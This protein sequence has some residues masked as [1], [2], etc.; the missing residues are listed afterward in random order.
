MDDELFEVLY[1]ISCQLW[2]SREKRVQFSGRTIVLLY[3]WSVIRNKPRS[4]VCHR[5]NLPA[6]LRDKPIPSQSQF[7]RRLNSTAVAALL[8]QME[9]SVRRTR[10]SAMLGCWILDGKPLPVSPYTKDKDAQLGWSYSGRAHGYKLFLMVDAEGQLAAWR[11]GG[12]NGGEPTIARSLLERTDRPGYVLGD[13]VYDS[14]PLHE[15]AAE[16]G[17]QLIAPRKQPRANIGSQSRHPSRLHA[18]DMLETFNNTFGPSMYAMRTVIERVFSQMSSSRVGLDHLPGFIRR[19]RRVEP[20]VRA[21]IILY[22]VQKP[23]ELRQ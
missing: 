7:G 16:R 13:S 21:K 14:C 11:V 8:T 15:L 20:W 22:C 9:D 4:W 5:Q 17:L 12:M 19:Q 18:I 6:R 23:K 1:H 3:L 10:R 2:P